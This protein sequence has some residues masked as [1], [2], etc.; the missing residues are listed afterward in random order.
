[1]KPPNG[2]NFRGQTITNGNFSYQDLTDADFSGATLISPYFAYA[3]LK[4]ANFQ[5]ATIYTPGATPVT[6]SDFS[7]A[8]LE[9][10]CFIDARFE[11][12]SYFTNAILTCADFSQV[13]LSGQNVV[14]GGGALVF[15]RTEGACRPAFR[16]AVM[17]CEF[18]DYWRYMDL[19]GADIKACASQFVNRDFSGA[20]LN[21]VDFAGAKLNGT[22]FVGA[23]L[24]EADFDNASLIG[25][26]LSNAS[27]F[28]AHMEL[29]NLTNASLYRALLT[30]N[31]AGGIHIAASLRRAHLKNANLSYAQLSGVD[32][33][34]AN[35]YGDDAAGEGECKTALSLGQC[36]GPGTDT[37]EGFAC[38]CASAYGATMTQTTLYRAYLYGVDFRGA[39]IQ[40]AN[41]E[42]AV[43]TGANLSGASISSGDGARSNF[44][45]AFLQ[46]TNLEGALITGAP[47]LSDAF[48]DFSK[49]NNMYILL[50]G[51]HNQFAGS[52]CPPPA[53]CPVCVSVN[54]T[55]PTTVPVGVSLIC[56]SR[57]SPRDCGPPNPDGSNENWRSTITNLASPPAPIPPA[58]Y[59]FRDSTYIKKLADPQSVCRGLVPVDFW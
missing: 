41:F 53:E 26:D 6:A 37:H 32:L 23:H 13:D 59:T 48:V 9:K 2:R 27:L 42:D 16:K 31:P 18:L 25:A 44:S 58:A 29:A 7:F 33:T 56:P 38:N 28:G 19:T 4:N 45:S 49:G 57:G 47:T 51:N 12:P 36:R 34:Y 50:D 14:F 52:K 10:A 15:D 39:Q 54:Y 35:L 46:G 22:R 40:G 21:N 3:N 43:L 8:N 11:G 55:G 1:V 24:S 20:W 17:D 5:G 30:S